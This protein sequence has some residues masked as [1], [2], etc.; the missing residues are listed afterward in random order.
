MKG[1]PKQATLSC[2]LAT[3]SQVKPARLSGN[4]SGARSLRLK[5]ANGSHAA[6]RVPGRRVRRP[7]RLEIHPLVLLVLLAGEQPQLEGVFVKRVAHRAPGDLCPGR[8]GGLRV[9]ED[10]ERRREDVEEVCSW[11]ESH[12]DP[13]NIVGREARGRRIN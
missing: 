8:E 6:W 3:A 10:P 7:H 11:N 9:S 12:L 1:S 13:E 2:G 5:G 4:G